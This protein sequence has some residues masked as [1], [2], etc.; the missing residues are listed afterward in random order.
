V[1]P[2]LFTLNL[3]ILGELTITSFGVMLALAFLSGHFVLRSELGRL[4][5]DREMSA[6]ALLGALV[7]GIVGAKLYYV[8]LY[9]DLTA[10]DPFGMLFSRGGL[11]WYGGFLGGVLGV[12]W[13]I[14]R[15]GA[16]VPLTADAIAPAL[17][18][19][20]SIGRLGCFLVGDDYGRPTNSFVGLAFPRGQPPSTAGNLRR[21][22]TD[23]DPAILDTEVLAV[24]PTQLY[25]SGLSLLFFFLL[26][27]LRAHP[28]ER[29]WLFA[30]WLAL[31]G[32]ERFFVELFR[33]KD[34]RFL[35]SFTLAQAISV[36]VIVVGVT[37]IMRFR[38][39]DTAVAG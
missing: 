26:V 24:H 2:E 5:A 20:Y 38:R 18:L 6:D 12:I 29:G 10:A 25:E 28:H 35:G 36:G 14:R 11:V 19:S 13:V 4:G 33:A 27:R 9:W 37:L 8:A 32:A 30:L 3:P 39:S 15:K 31:A 1:Y 22:G 7:G 21:F 34:D 16:S 17:A 23:V